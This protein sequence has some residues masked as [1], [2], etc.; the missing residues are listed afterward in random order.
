MKFRF[1]D[2]GPIEEAELELG[3]FTI[4]AG[5]NN[6]GK[7]YLV[8]T[9]YGF[10]KGSRDLLW[11]QAGS[12]FL[13]S[14]FEK[15][16]ALS[17][18][19]VVNKLIAE[20]Q[21]EWNVEE[22]VL[23]EEQARLIQ[24]M[25]REFSENG[26]ARV[27]NTSKDSFEDSALDIEFSREVRP[28]RRAFIPIRQGRELSIVY[29]GTKLSVSLTE[30]EPIGDSD[31][32][33]YYI[34]QMF[35]YMYGYFSLQDFFAFQNTSFIFSSARHSIPLFS[36]ELDFARSQVVRLLQQREDGKESDSTLDFDPLRHTSRYALPIQDNIDFTRRM[37][38][39]AERNDN[40]PQSVFTE[41]IEKMMEGFFRSISGQL[42][43][44]ASEDNRL[45]FDIPLHLASS[46]AWEMSNLYFF[47]GYFMEGERSHFLI[48]DEPES[49]L[50]TAN[51]I[52]LARLLTRLVNSGVKV[53]ITTHSDYIIREVNNLILLNSFKDDEEL[54]DELDFDYRETDHLSEK[55]VKAYIA[56]EGTGT[57]KECER[58]AFGIRMPVFD[59][60]IEKMNRVST[61]LEAKLTMRVEGA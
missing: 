52:R 39:R 12:L 46:S 36:N 59:D 44:I 45:E 11:S 49:H 16:L 7:S 23:L 56:E 10:L 60:T 41:D 61:D 1:K 17:T 3:D 58:D 2:I 51:Q 24:A 35:R 14:H 18:D 20:G 47:L 34:N 53:L 6:T 32:E 4:I 57:L 28:N 50:D 54:L 5:R 33:P 40:K 26:I 27:F 13:E 31:V 42:R 29:D 21:I 15:M 25:T 55:R 38:G 43:F 19:D 48:I 9:L 8:H 30:A 37:T 22:S